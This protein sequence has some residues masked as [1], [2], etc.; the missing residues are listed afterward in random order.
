MK[1]AL[2]AGPL[3]LGLLMLGMGVAKG[4]DAP[5]MNILVEDLEEE[6]A[7]ACGIDESSIESIATLTLRNNGIQV[8]A[9]DHPVYLYVHVTMIVNNAGCIANLRVSV[10][11]DLFPKASLDGFKPRSRAATAELCVKGVL[12]TESRGGMRDKILSKVEENTKLCL[13]ELEY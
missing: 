9:E 8:S 11:S 10:V 4:N 13:G 6:A 1:N 2:L 3:V 5:S 7:R 12:L